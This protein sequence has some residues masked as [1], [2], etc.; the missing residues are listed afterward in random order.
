[1]GFVLLTPLF[2]GD[3]VTGR[4][5]IIAVTTPV[6]AGSPRHL[7]DKHWYRSRVR[8]HVATTARPFPPNPVPVHFHRRLEG[9]R[10]V[11]DLH[12]LGELVRVRIHGLIST[13][14]KL[15]DDRGLAGSRHPRQKNSLHDDIPSAVERMVQQPRTSYEGGKMY[16]WEFHATKT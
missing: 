7:R 11:D 10:V 14:S 4:L 8:Q 2:G 6:G 1:M 9:A 3:Q 5:S 12:P 15:A 16:M 13:C